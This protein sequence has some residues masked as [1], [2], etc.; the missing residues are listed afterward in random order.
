MLAVDA[1]QISGAVALLTGAIVAGAA[2]TNAIVQARKGPQE[3]ASANVSQ[4]S[5]IIDAMQKLADELR[6]ELER[7][8]DLVASVRADALAKIE[9]LEA[10]IVELRATIV[11]LRAEAAR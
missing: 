4:L 11:E 1:V 10:I 3:T 9:Q 5:Q 2:L 7:S 6:K 8:Q